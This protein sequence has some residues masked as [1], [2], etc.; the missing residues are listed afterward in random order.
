MRRRYL[1]KVIPIVWPDGRWIGFMVHAGN[2]WF[3]PFI[4]IGGLAP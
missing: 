2:E 4:S 3:G 1:A